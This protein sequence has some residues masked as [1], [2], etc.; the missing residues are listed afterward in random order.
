MI[1]AMRD[2]PPIPP[3]PPPPPCFGNVWLTE[4]AGE[5]VHCFRVKK[6]LFQG[7]TEFADVEILDTY[8]YGKILAIDGWTQ[9]AQDDEVY[10]HEALVAPA[11]ALGPAPARRVAILGGGEGATLREVLR[12]RDVERCTMV[13]IDAELVALC[14]EHLPEWA[15][16][17]F[18][19]P[20]AELVA[21]DARAFLAETRERFD[22]IIADLPDAEFGDPLQDLYSREFYD[23]V[24]AR[25]APGGIF[26]TQSVDALALGTNLIQTPAIR[27]TVR[28]AFGEAHVYA[29]YIPSFWSEWTWVLAGPGLE[30]RDPAEVAPD[31]IDARLAARRDPR[32]PCRT[33]DGE[34]HRHLFSLMRDLR[35]VLRYD[36]PIVVDRA[37][38]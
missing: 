13:D 6:V 9:S 24:R 36:G 2:L 30:G 23:L 14:R 12:F 18:E 22:V 32:F 27:R 10:Y 1:H 21:G 34:A 31:A 35:E 16:G 5:E 25:L 38:A 11:L 26:V 33:Y 4:A 17:A 19:D 29:R 28:A 37:R 8:G 15:A 7:E 20:R 3:P